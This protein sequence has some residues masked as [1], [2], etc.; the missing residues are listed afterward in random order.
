L[1]FV[2]AAN[3][4]KRPTV[5]PRRIELVVLHSTENQ[6]RAG[7]AGTVAAWFASGQVEASAHYVVDADA[8]IQCVQEKDIA[9]A[10]PGANQGGVHVELAGKASQTSEQWL[11]GYSMAVLEL[12]AALVADICRRNNLPA[13]P[14]GSAGLLMGARGIT[15]HAA[16]SVAFKKSDHTDPGEGFPLNTF[17]EMVRKKAA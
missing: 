6:E 1:R 13:T 3:Y 2:E 9:W 11:D 10:A 12:A 8:V 7:I 17:V 5:S 14:I 4:T 15:T 16:V